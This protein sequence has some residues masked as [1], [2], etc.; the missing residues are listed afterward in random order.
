MKEEFVPR[1]KKIYSLSRKE[2]EK[3]EKKIH[4][5]FEIALNN[6]SVLYRKKE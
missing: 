4:K 2:K 6:T 1:K 5:T 3:V